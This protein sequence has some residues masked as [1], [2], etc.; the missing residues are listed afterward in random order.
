MQLNKQQKIVAGYSAAMLITLVMAWSGGSGIGMPDFADA[1]PDAK[2][3][4]EERGDSLETYVFLSDTPFKNA[5]GE[6]DGFLGTDWRRKKMVEDD[7]RRLSEHL[8]TET[9]ESLTGI[10]LYQ[11]DL[12]P[13]FR[14]SLAQSKAP[15]SGQKFLTT[16]SVFE[17]EPKAGGR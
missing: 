12:T 8:D 16:L 4:N 5:R 14:V 3:V 11:N 2:L 1:F 9:L 7:Y 10:A 17:P 13:G 15:M 6:L